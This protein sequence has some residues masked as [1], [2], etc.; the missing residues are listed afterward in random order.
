MHALIWIKNPVEIGFSG[1]RP[2]TQEKAGRAMHCGFNVRFVRRR[3]PTGH[4]NSSCRKLT[5][6][7]NKAGLD[8]GKSQTLS[9]VAR[10]VDA[11]SLRQSLDCW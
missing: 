10:E 11:E 9:R 5:P 4:G 8:S 2:A 7:P 6:A 1:G 3:Q